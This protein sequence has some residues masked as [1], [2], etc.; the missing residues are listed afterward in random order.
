VAS[1]GSSRGAR[2]IEQ[3]R[4]EWPGIPFQY[5]SRNQFGAEMQAFK[6]FV[7]TRETLSGTVNG[8]DVRTAQSK[9]SGLAAG[10]C[11][12]IGDELSPDIAQ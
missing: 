12:K 11:A 9:L 6:I 8:G 1:D 10:R 7:Q 5:V 3:Y 4:I 2:R